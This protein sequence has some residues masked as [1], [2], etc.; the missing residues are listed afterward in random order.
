LTPIGRILNRF[1][2]DLDSLDMQLPMFMYEFIQAFIYIIGVIIVCAYTSWAT[3]VILV[4]MLFMF[5]RVRQYFSC[6]S[7]ELKRLEAVSRSPVFSLF[8]ETVSGLP[9]LRAFKMIGQ[10]AETFDGCCDANFKIFF[11]L[12]SLTSWLIYRLD[13]MGSCMI[14]SIGL[15]CFWLPRTQETVAILGLGLTTAT[16][17]MGR[18]HMTVQF[19]IETEN[20]MTS[21][22]RLQHF[23]TIPKEANTATSTEALSEDWPASGHIQFQNIMMRYR[24]Q[25][26][27]VLNNLSFEVHAGAKL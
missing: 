13:S 21:V 16:G 8:G 19:S 3:L 11:H 17:L 23:A 15:S 4:P 25:L 2:K 12:Y 5:Y 6:T 20:H 24:P 10:Q 27:L 14:L 22:E 18:L 1:S 7:R 26:P 9:H